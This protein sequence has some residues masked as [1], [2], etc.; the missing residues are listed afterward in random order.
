MRPSLSPWA[1]VALL[2]AAAALVGAAPTPGYIRYPDFG[3]SP[4]T[5]SYDAR[6][7]L[8]NGSH[9]LILSG[10]IHYP[11]TTPQQWADLFDKALND[12]FNAVETYYFWNAHE[13]K[14]GQYDTS[15]EKDIRAYISLAAQKGLFVILRIGPYICAEWNYGGFPLFINSVPGLTVRSS[16][17]KWEAIMEA[18]FA[19]AVAEVRDLFADAGGPIIATQCD[20]EYASW[21]CDGA[22]GQCDNDYVAWC[23]QLAATYSPVPAVMCNGLAANNSHVFASTNGNDAATYLDDGGTNDWVFTTE[24]GVWTEN[25]GWFTS[26]GMPYPYYTPSSECNCDPPQRTPTSMA[27]TILRFFS[28]GGSLHNYYMYCGG[29]HFGRNAGSSVANAYANGANFNADGL[30][31]ILLNYRQHLQTVHHLIV[32]NA[33]ALITSAPQVWNRTYLDRLEGGKWVPGDNTTVAFIYSNSEGYFEMWENSQNNAAVLRWPGGGRGGMRYNFSSWS[34]QVHAQNGTVIFDSSVVAPAALQRIYTP[35]NPQTGQPATGSGP[36]FVWS[37]WAESAT[38]G[39]DERLR[40]VPASSRAPAFSTPSTVGTVIT[41]P[42]P[43]EQLNVTEDDTEYMLY[44]RDVSMAE[45]KRIWGALLS[46]AGGDADAALSSAGSVPLFIRSQI[47]QGFIAFVDGVYASDT[48]NNTHNFRTVNGSFVGTCNYSQPVNI[49]A[50]IRRLLALGATGDA[51]GSAAFTLT[52]VAES[53]GLDNGHGA[54][55]VNGTSFTMKGIV[56]GVSLNGVDITYG[57]TWTM[58]SGLIGEALAVFSAQ[59]AANVT[60]TPVPA[61]APVAGAPLT[62]YRAFFTAPSNLTSM[63]LPQGQNSTSVTTATPRTPSPEVLASLLFDIGDGQFLGRGHFYLNGF[64]LGRYWSI[65]GYNTTSPS[66]RY[67]FLPADLLVPEVEG[68]NT[69]T[70]VDVLP[71][72]DLSQAQLV[73]SQ[74]APV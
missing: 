43:L 16:D 23:G 56:S 11:R 8:L 21:A 34:A 45:L 38:I 18:T 32:E 74:L 28:R 47:S 9:T 5:V 55:V 63:L 65:L 70:L 14:P 53:L 22:I 29:N 73:L 15:F 3:G 57:S 62:W 52:I 51:D 35:L 4:Y 12:G 64:D 58:R 20:N 36:G 31:N 67:Y 37:K 50:P 48:S 7:L 6:S 24:P 54:W 10:S 1:T 44:S 30:P 46:A 27:Y 60:W 13:H 49:S 72:A 41:S 66:Q 17:P 25:E 33:P 40:A 19:R 2:G 39:A 26:W 71:T 68:G 61:T 69:I 42:Y 59:G